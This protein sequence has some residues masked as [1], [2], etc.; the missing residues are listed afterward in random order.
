MG[1]G[2]EVGGDELSEES[3]ADLL[4]AAELGEEIEGGGVVV[5]LCFWE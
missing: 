4:E 3:L 1:T 2:G 5:E